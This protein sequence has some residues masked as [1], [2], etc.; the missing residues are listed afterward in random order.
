V[1]YL[2]IFGGEGYCFFSKE[3]EKVAVNLLHHGSYGR[4]V[5]D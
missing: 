3:E 4:G 5:V 1:G 2:S